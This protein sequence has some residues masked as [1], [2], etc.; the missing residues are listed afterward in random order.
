MPSKTVIHLVIAE[1]QNSFILITKS[2]VE[3]KFFT[4][5][6]CHVTLFTSKKT[7]E[8]KEKDVWF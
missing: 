2:D 3:K 5:Y 7:S 6:L 1:V 8:D 4:L